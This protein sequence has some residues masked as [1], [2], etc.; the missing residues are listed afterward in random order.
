MQ[1]RRRRRWSARPTSIPIPRPRWAARTSPS[2]CRRRPAAMSG[3]APAAAQIRRT[4]TARSTTS[5]TRSCRSARPTGSRSRNSS[6]RADRPGRL[7][8]LGAAPAQPPDRREL[9]ERAGELGFRERDLL[10]R[11]L[12]LHRVL[13]AL[14]RLERLGL[15]EVV[16]PDR[17]VREDGDDVGLH[18]EEA[19]LHEHDLLL[20][21]SGHLDA[22]FARLDL[23]DQRRVLGIDPEL[24][25]DAG[26]YHELR[27]PAEYGFAEA[28]DVDVNGV[29]HHWSVLAFAA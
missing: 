11:G 3:S 1:P 24:A 14:L 22:H 19:A 9:G 29:R 12:V 7:V 13:G 25:H 20:V 21:A 23:R 26:Q 18:L 27:L 6:W 8:P 28:H 17:G 16:R 5:T 2:C 4:S 10:L 15:V